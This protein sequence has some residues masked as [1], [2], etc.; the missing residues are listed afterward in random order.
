MPHEMFQM[1]FDAAEDIA[2]ARRVAERTR[3]DSG[4]RTS[5]AAVAA[6]LGVD[7]DSL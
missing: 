2:I 1:L 7:L 6:D 5:L 4:N 3:S